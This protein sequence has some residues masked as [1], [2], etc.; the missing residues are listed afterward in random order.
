MPNVQLLR[1]GLLRP[2]FCGTG[3]FQGTY[4]YHLMKN[5]VTIFQEPWWCE[6]CVP[7]DWDVV[8]YCEDNRV[9][10]SF[11]YAVKKVAG[12]VNIRMPPLARAMVPVMKIDQ[13][14]DVTILLRK[15]KIVNGLCRKLPNFLTFKYV[16]PPETGMDLAFAL[17]GF[18]TEVEY[19]FRS[20]GVPDASPLERMDQKVRNI[21]K[22]NMGRYGIT[23]HRDFDRYARLARESFAR[24]PGGGSHQISARG[25]YF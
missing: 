8:E 9:V 24:C 23:A 14:K 1:V 12:T 25:P 4:L 5:S 21:L 10:A 3:N 6:A 18:N 16:L 17:N 15:I 2:D 13:K 22:T 7:G 20:K 11:T 19:T